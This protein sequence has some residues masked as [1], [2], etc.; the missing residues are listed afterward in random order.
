MNPNNPQQPSR[1]GP[2]GGPPGLGGGGAGGVAPPAI[3]PMK[4]LVK[5]KYILVASVVLGIIVGFA[6]FIGLRRLSP[7]FTATVIFEALP[8]EDSVEDISVANIDSDEMDRFIGTQV[9][10]MRSDRVLRKVVSDPRLLQE[11][12]DWASQYMRGGQIDVI[13]A[14]EDIQDQVNAG[15]IPD[16]FLINLRASA[17]NPQDAAGLVRMVKEA[18]LSTL[19]TGFNRDIVSRRSSLSDSLDQTTNQINE[20]TARKARL[21]REERIDSVNSDQSATAAQLA[22]VNSELIR[23]QQQLEAMRVMR[24]EDQAQLDRETGIEY[25]STLRAEVEQNP[26]IQNFKQQL[27]SFETRLLSL[28][29]DGYQPEHRA[30]KRT[31]NQIEAHERKIEKAREELLRD[32][33]EA[34]LSGTIR[35]IAQFEA[36]QA[37]LQTQKEEHEEKLTELTRITEEIKDIDRQIAAMITRQSEQESALSDL[38]SSAALQSSQ[39]VRVYQSETLP[40]SPSFPK[41]VIIVPAGVLVISGLTAGLIF[42]YEFLDQR[43]KSASD[44]RSIARVRALGSIMHLSEDP[45]KPERIER[46]CIDHPGSVLA[47]HV[48]QL[49]TVLAKQMQGDGLSTLVISGVMPG[50]GATTLIANLAFAGAGAGQRVAVLDANVRR[51]RIHEMFGLEQGEGLGEILKLGRDLDD[52]VHRVEGGPDVILAGAREHRSPDML[53][54]AAMRGLL[55]TLKSRYDLVLIDAAPAV[56]SGDATVLANQADATML[57]ARAMSEKKGQVARV[58]REMGDCRAR[59][60]GVVVNAVQSSAGGYMGKNIRTAFAYHTSTEQDAEADT[61]KG[62]KP[63]DAA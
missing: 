17:G 9:A 25:D 53:S 58:S 15:A 23:I 46:V 48:R 61:E 27:K 11:A 10:T 47:E 1:G 50:S 19:V 39:R 26:L 41:L 49:R 20:L 33:F 32:R 16:T 54:G 42:L 37:D 63:R 2:P 55:D 51:P 6:S 38:R 34:R 21:V 29:S 7:R 22:L 62:Q 40:D 60:L 57:V 35:T 13:K 4:L 12:R 8:V 52:R 18:Y 56:V 43:V 3:N 31:V 30:Y 59:F 5:Y 14:F 45:S 28:K 44:I 36:Q 24:A